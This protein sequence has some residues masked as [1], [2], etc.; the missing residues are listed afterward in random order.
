[1]A[2]TTRDLWTDRVRRWRES[3]LTARQF[4]E[5]ESLNPTT[6][7]WWSSR[8]N[9]GAPAAA[10]FIELALPRAA[11][12]PAIEVVVRDGVRVRV[13]GGFDPELLR[14]VVAALEAR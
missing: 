4:G 6:L 8:L 13:A 5:R 12:P 14:Q 2:K 10:T 11:E 9:R 1:M 3:G 7:R